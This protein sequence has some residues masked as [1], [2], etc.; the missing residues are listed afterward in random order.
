MEV[1]AYFKLQE[2][3]EYTRVED[4]T[5]IISHYEMLARQGLKQS[6]YCAVYKN[7]DPQLHPNWRYF[8]YLRELCLL[9]GWDSKK[10]LEVQF[11]RFEGYQSK[12]KIP[13]PNMLCSDNAI[14][15]TIKE[16]GT[17]KQ[18]YKKDIG[19]KRKERGKQTLDLRQ[20][21]KKDIHTS[22]KNLHWYIESN[23]MIEDKA[24]YKTV[25]IF[26]S[27]EEMSPYYLWT[28]PW[29]KDVLPDLES[30][31]KDEYIEVFQQIDKSNTMK[32]TIM[33]EVKSLESKYNI[34]QNLQLQ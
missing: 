13:Y 1:K 30:K 29:F 8:E 28:I 32:N 3:N 10:Y 9:K 7:K 18:T 31:K 12:F 5:E 17:I 23:T 33:Q 24:Q 6:G 4:I 16:L 27:W 19:G 14:K 21:I 22:I 2:L 34:P 11:K 25:K 15:Y 20:E 26:Q